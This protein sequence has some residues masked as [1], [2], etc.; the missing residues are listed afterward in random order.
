[1]LSLQLR[2]RQEVLGGA[3]SVRPT[4]GASVGMKQITPLA[5]LNTLIIFWQIDA[6]VASSGRAI[7][8]DIHL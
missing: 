7:C 5:S 1:M 4:L 8:L 3:Q 6:R 2:W